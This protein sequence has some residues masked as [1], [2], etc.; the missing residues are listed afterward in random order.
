MWSKDW[1]IVVEDDDDWYV[2]LLIVG[3]GGCSC[4]FGCEVTVGTVSF[5]LFGIE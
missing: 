2:L 1:L 3:T 5:R 4:W